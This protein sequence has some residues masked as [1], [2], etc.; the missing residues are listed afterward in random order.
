[1]SKREKR[2]LLLTAAAVIYGLYAYLGPSTSKPVLESPQAKRENL[3][4]FVTNVAARLRKKDVSALDKYVIARAKSQWPHDPFLPTEAVFKATGE[5]AEVQAKTIDID[6]IYSGYIEMGASRLAII[7]GMEYK[8]GEEIE[9]GGYAVKK[10]TPRE[11]VIGIING[12]HE[13]T[14]PL[15]EAE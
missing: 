7:N 4:D 12:T 14:F 9:P 6:F 13:S 15:K 5:Q 8:V 10:I 11:V 2:I 3:N 1:M